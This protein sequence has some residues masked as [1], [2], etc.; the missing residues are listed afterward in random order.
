MV[1]G[2]QQVAATLEGLVQGRKDI[3]KKREDTQRGVGPTVIAAIHCMLYL[4]VK[5][6]ITVNWMLISRARVAMLLLP[7]SQLHA[8]N[9][10]L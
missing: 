9:A 1:A 7:A 3:V 5:S 4:S 10:S 2:N 6:C 8:M